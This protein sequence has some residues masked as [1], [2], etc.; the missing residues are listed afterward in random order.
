MASK[1]FIQALDL[2]ESEKGCLLYTSNDIQLN[3]LEKLYKIFDKYFNKFGM[4]IGFHAFIDQN[5]QTYQSIQEE[6]DALNEVQV[7]MKTFDQ[8]S[9]CLLYTSRCV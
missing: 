4:Q 6:M 8:V 7:D 1:K 2:L 3:Q 9:D 5:N